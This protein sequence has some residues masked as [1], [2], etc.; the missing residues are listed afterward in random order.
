MEL[1]VKEGVDLRFLT[2]GGS[3]V[4]GERVLRGALGFELGVSDVAL[5]VTAV[6][7]RPDPTAGEGGSVGGASRPMCGFLNKASSG[8]K[9]GFVRLPLNDEAPASSSSSLV[10]HVASSGV[11]YRFRK[12]LTSPCVGA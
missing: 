10:A 8:G 12:T 7:S 11:V 1:D 2:L 4:T 3:E 5:G 6:V 9:A